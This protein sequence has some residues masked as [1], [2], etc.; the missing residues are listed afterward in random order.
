MSQLRQTFRF[1]TVVRSAGATSVIQAC[2]STPSVK[3]AVLT[4]SC[5]AIAY[6]HKEGMGSKVWT[7]ADWTDADAPGVG[8]YVESKTRAERAGEFCRRCCQSTACWCAALRSLCGAPRTEA[9]VLRLPSRRFHCVAL[10]SRSM[11]RRQGAAR[12]AQARV[13][14]YQPEPGPGPDALER[15]VCQPGPGQADH[16]RRNARPRRRVHEHCGC[17]RCG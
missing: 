8:A 1:L 13:R 17:A 4:S 10:A 9:S 12:G 7:P 5:A 3:R 11:G 16:S 15:L 14:D 2:V 6:G